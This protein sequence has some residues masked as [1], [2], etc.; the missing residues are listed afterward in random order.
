M[1][2]SEVIRVIQREI[3]DND[4]I[5][6]EKDIELESDGNRLKISINKDEIK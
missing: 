1:K 3:M 4:N 6:F 5:E 2:L